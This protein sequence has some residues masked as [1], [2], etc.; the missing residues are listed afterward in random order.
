MP[1]R[2][3]VS[4]SNF[5]IPEGQDK[6]L[7]FIT[8]KLKNT[9]G[10]TDTLSELAEQS[11]ASQRTIARLFLNETGMTF[12]VWRERLRIIAAVEKLIAGESV[13]GTALDLGYQSASSFTT[14]FT[15]IVGDPP[16]KYT[17]RCKS[18]MFDCPMT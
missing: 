11:C 18:I 7:R 10:C 12:L 6:R 3:N 16:R 5:F 17:R 1:V 14:A 13:L 9:P 4:Q 15:R 8:Q 2:K